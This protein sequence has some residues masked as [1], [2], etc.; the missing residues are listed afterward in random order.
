LY[1]CSQRRSFAKLAECSERRTAIEFLAIGA[2]AAFD[3]AIDLGAARE[4][5]SML[6]P[7]VTEIPGEIGAE[8]VAVVGLYALD[9]PGEPLAHL[10]HEGDRV[11]NE[12][13]RVDPEDPVQTS[14][15][16]GSALLPVHGGR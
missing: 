16:R 13:A 3:L 8:L 12:I 4:D 1:S 6:D 14:Q 7:E 5:M 15:A 9:G 11:R 10:I 2:V